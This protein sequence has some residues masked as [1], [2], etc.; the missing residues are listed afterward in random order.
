MQL[1]WGFI[2]FV[3]AVFAAVGFA[4]LVAGLRDVWRTARSRR[5]PTAPGTVVSTEELQHRR[6]VPSDTGSGVRIH[7]EAR[8]HYEYTVGQVHIG[9][10][11]VRLGTSE[12]SSEA[13]AQTTLARYLPGQ[14]IQVAYNPQDPTE[15]VLEPGAHPVDFA[16]ALVG[17]A[18]LVLA[19]AIQLISRWFLAH[20]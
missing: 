14:S 16:R 17:A 18:L 11:V 15:S 19:F 7:Y 8:V 10:T 5:W 3:C 20:V 2:H 6:R 4:L 13:H 12:T 1:L 9:S